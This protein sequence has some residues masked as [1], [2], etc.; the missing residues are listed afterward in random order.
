MN[1]KFWHC[2]FAA[3]QNSIPVLMYYSTYTVTDIRDKNTTKFPL[4]IISLKK[5][6][7]DLVTLFINKVNNICPF[8]L[9]GM[10]SRGGC[11]VIHP[12]NSLAI[13]LRY[14]LERNALYV[15]QAFPYFCDSYIINIALLTFI[16]FPRIYVWLQ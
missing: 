8:L 15:L 12:G 2:L 4:K 3:P 1:T 10:K 13:C 6:L 11:W 7:W 14:S 16:S 9:W 5:S